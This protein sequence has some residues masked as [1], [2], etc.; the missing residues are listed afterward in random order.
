VTIKGRPALWAA[1]RI[2]A[3]TLSSMDSMETWP[4]VSVVVVA[5]ICFAIACSHS[6]GSIRSF[7]AMNHDGFVFHAGEHHLIT[8]SCRIPAYLGRID[9]RSL[10]G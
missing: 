3:A 4:E 8:E 10:S 5:W 9:D 2:A 6:G 7:T 1:S